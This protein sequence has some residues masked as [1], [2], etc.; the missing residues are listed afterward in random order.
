MNQDRIAELT[1]IVKSCLERTA[2][3]KRQ[4]ID[5]AK[6]C[7]DAQIAAKELLGHG[8]FDQWRTENFPTKA[9]ATLAKHKRIAEKWDQ[10][11]KLLERNPDMGVTAIDKALVQKKRME[12]AKRSSPRKW[13]L[14]K[15]RW[16]WDRDDLPEEEKHRRQHILRDWYRDMLEGWR[17]PAPTGCVRS[18][19]LD[20]GAFSQQQEAAKRQL[21]GGTLQ[22][23]Y[24]TAEYHEYRD[25]YAEFVKRYRKAI[26]YYANLDVIGD[27]ELTWRNQQYLE[28]VHHC[29]PIPVVHYGT[30][31]D[32]GWL[33]DYIFS[34]YDYIALGGLVG[35]TT[36]PACR[37]WIRRCFGIA[38]EL[39]TPDKQIK[40][41]GFGVGSQIS[42]SLFPWY[43]VDTAGWVKTS[44]TGYILVPPKENGEFTFTKPPSTVYVGVYDKGRDDPVPE[45]P[46]EPPCE[47]DAELEGVPPKRIDEMTPE[48]QAYVREWVEYLGVR[49]GTPEGK[50]NG[51]INHYSHRRLAV[52]KYLAAVAAHYGIRFY[53]SGS[54]S[55][56]TNPEVLL[57]D[58]ANV[59]LTYYELDHNPQ[60][61]KLQRRFA[62]LLNARRRGKLTA[63][64]TPPYDE[65]EED[66][67]FLE[68]TELEFDTDQPNSVLPEA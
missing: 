48:E 38:A 68:G 51:V 28:Q 20:S 15:S 22:D 47:T 60:T 55:R 65:D 40:I 8:G 67:T 64:P 32:F 46:N 5:V 6:E 52:M 41:H 35:N 23:Y 58:D 49:W 27:P 37:E 56:H 2:T 62:R 59:M 26:D 9:R 39:S 24:R 57:G 29:T 12:E 3:L 44:G 31:D 34:G 63:P 10:V 54:G 14:S 7:G 17:R 25:R 61:D 18:H 16:L 36:K 11:Q 53:F 4:M 13:F 43:S 66:Y 21:A 45:H 30:D 33:C 1:A 50:R 42:M 19:F